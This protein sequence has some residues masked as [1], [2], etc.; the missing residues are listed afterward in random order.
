VPSLP[1]FGTGVLCNLFKII[2]MCSVLLCLNVDQPASGSKEGGS[3][4]RQ[5]TENFFM[6]CLVCSQMGAGQGKTS[7]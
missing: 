5:N 6:L 7:P 3:Q 1:Y 2:R 4:V